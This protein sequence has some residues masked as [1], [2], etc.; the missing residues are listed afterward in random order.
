MTYS[1]RNA[2]AST[3][4]RDAQGEHKATKNIS[5]RHHQQKIISGHRRPIMASAFLLVLSAVNHSSA[6]ATPISG[7][8]QQS[9]SSSF[10]VAALKTKQGNSDGSSVVS[11]SVLAHLWGHDD[12]DNDKEWMIAPS[13]TGSRLLQ[14]EDLEEDHDDHDHDEVTE[15]VTAAV[16]EDSAHEEDD[17]D[18]HDH[19]NEEESDGHD[20]HDLDHEDEHLHE[21]E[22]ADDHDDHDDH[23][24]SSHEA[25]TDEFA[26]TTASESKANSEPWGAVIGATLLVNLATFSGV[27]LLVLP[28][29]YRGVL[30]YRNV[31]IGSS[32]AAHGSGRFYDIVVPGFAV[33]ALV[34]TAVF[35]VLPESVKYLSG[36]GHAS[37][38]DHMEEEDGGG[39]DDHAGHGHR[40]LEEDVHAG[41]GSAAAKF[42]CSVLGGFLLPF[43]FAIFFHHPDPIKDGEG[44][45]KQSREGSV[46]IVN[47]EEDCETCVDKHDDVEI[48]IAVAAP[49]DSSNPIQQEENATSRS[50]AFQDNAAN[51]S[52][53]VVNKRLCASILLG[54]GFHN[55][56][57]GFFIA[58][59]FR[60]CS[61]A[62]AIS[63][64]LVT[65]FHEIAQELA[66]FIV[67][68]K[69]GGLPV[70]KALAF[71]F[72]SGLT[73]CLGG[74]VFLATTPTDTATGVILAAAGGVYIN[75]AAVETAPRMEGAMKGRGDRAL[76]LFSII[77]GTIPL[78]LILLDHKHCG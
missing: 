53:P 34:A 71:N 33:G 66:D 57:D 49:Q 73:V 58:A 1:P 75:I 24:H 11:S 28:A 56:A 38:A 76:M 72:L 69:F 18:D 40:K 2:A 64:M 68:T 6:S 48:G 65:L 30:K 46:D 17:H 77:L 50:D 23:D 12:N 47:E 45:T 61:V 70:W 14:E 19:A 39:H 27:L 31:P 5:R 3:N 4:E 25:H 10:G 21:D 26:S 7:R 44:T 36:E 8:T 55:F 22:V 78:G 67:L 16:E 63:I 54:D 32:P 13:S 60:S 29:M 62:V 59:A 42:G 15:A 43:V 74:I 41:E 37:H 9:A 51:E 35:L 20:D 52:I